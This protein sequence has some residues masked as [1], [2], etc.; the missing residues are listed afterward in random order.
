MLQTDDLESKIQK[1]QYVI[2]S[3]KASFH[4]SI[5]SKPKSLKPALEQPA[6]DSLYSVERVL[7]NGFNRRSTILPTM[8]N[9]PDSMR[10]DMICQN[11]S[12]SLRET[13]WDE[14]ANYL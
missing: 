2:S 6:N 3:S 7:L 8:M 11:N 1:A 13:N 9:S 4:M 5:S 14:K 10:L 12:Q